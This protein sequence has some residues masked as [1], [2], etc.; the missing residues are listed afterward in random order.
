MFDTMTSTKIVAALCGALLFF[1]LGKWVAES[2][3]HVESKNPGVVELAALEEVEESVEDE[4]SPVDIKELLASADVTK[5]QRVFTK[6]QA[7]HKLE[8]GQ[9][10][11]GPHLFNIIDRPIG[12]VSDYKYSSAMADFEGSWTVDELSQYLINPK[13]YLPGT[14]M[15]FAGLKK[16]MDRANL[17]AYLIEATQ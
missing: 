15:V 16:D 2:I 9:N 6:C 13:K 17:I 4:A 14:K 5:G 1:L 11:V 12:D 7:C 8:D 10:T 3:Y